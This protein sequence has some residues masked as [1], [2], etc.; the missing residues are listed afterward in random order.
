LHFIVQVPFIDE[1]LDG[2]AAITQ[3]LE[4]GQLHS[5]YESMGHIVQAQAEPQARLVLLNKLML[6]PNQYWTAII[7]Q[8]SAD[9][10][11]VFEPKTVK[12]TA[13]LLK[14]NHRVAIAVGSS[15][16]VQLSRIYTEMLQL[17]KMY[18]E[19]IS[20]EVATKGAVVTGH[21]IIRNMRA[22]KK[23]VLKLL[24]VFI[25]QS[26][27]ADVPNLCQN[28]LPAMLDPLLG[29]YSR[30]VAGARDA[31]VLG[32]FATIVDKLGVQTQT[33]VRLFVCMCTCVRACV[34]VCVCDSP[35]LFVCASDSRGR[36]AVTNHRQCSCH[37]RGVV[38]MH[39]GHDHAKLY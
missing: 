6:I 21:T 17:Y 36:V 24:D 27:P 38:S 12:T 28:F 33:R 16:I 11:S 1:M 32:L 2:L 20:N 39:I 4:P 18:S 3:D 19:F 23:E 37:F 31:E 13:S 7:G 30:N 5:V 25:E 35:I 29:D 15:Y 10:A 34:C 14:T 9:L 8:A 26:E 22:V